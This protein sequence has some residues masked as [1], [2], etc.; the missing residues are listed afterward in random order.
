MIKYVFLI[1]VLAFYLSGF[2]AQDI[3][4]LPTQV[5]MDKKLIPHFISLTCII[6]CHET[7]LIKLII[8]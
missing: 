7:T 8:A 6:K 2:H 5:K 1:Q 4:L 3:L